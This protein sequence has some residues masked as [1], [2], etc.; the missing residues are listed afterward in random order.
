[1]RV[2]DTVLLYAAGK[3][4]GPGK[5]EGEMTSVTICQ[6]L[7]NPTGSFSGVSPHALEMD[8]WCISEASLPTLTPAHDDPSGCSFTI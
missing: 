4:P 6:E 1:M 3:L 8:L 5:Q 2:L 7:D